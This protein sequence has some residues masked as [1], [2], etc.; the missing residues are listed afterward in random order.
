MGYQISNFE[1]GHVPTY[2][3]SVIR[4]W[5]SHTFGDFSA[6]ENDSGKPSVAID[7]SW[8]SW[9]P[10][11]CTVYSI[12][13]PVRGYSTVIDLTIF[14]NSDHLLVGP[15]NQEATAGASYMY[16]GSVPVL[17]SGFSHCLAPL[18]S[19]KSRM[20]T[21]DILMN[22]IKKMHYYYPKINMT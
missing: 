3:G 6:S 13:I 17:A 21:C 22:R 1:L 10:V 15:P 5:K 2:R 8:P 12:N 20:M 16:Q 4:P 11:H 14:S 18:A 19:G 9:F 7:W